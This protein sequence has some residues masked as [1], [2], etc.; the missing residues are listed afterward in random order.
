[1]LVFLKWCFLQ[2]CE[3]LVFWELAS[4]KSQFYKDNFMIVRCRP[5]KHHSW[6]TSFFWENLKS[7]FNEYA[8]NYNSKSMFFVFFLEGLLEARFLAGLSK[9]SN[10]SS[11]F[12]I[13]VFF[14]VKQL[15]YY[16][17]CA[18]TST[19]QLLSWGASGAPS[20]KQEQQFCWRG[21]LK[22]HFWVKRQKS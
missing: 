5:K 6:K 19:S 9:W 15:I 18:H 4:R 21:M 11:G 20:G 17:T 22:T 13:F 14:D 12:A 2:F 10:A 16:C 3:E 7:W 1:M 8:V